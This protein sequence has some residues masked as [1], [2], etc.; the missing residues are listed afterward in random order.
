MRNTE[1]RKKPRVALFSVWLQAFF[2]FFLHLL[3]A[4]H[5]PISLVSGLFHCTHRMPHL[6]SQHPT[7]PPAVSLGVVKFLKHN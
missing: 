7:I 6:L 5:L 1:A 4:T 3:G 2:F